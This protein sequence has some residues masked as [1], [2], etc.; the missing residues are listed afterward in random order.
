[1]AVEFRLFADQVER[2]EINIQAMKLATSAAGGDWFSQ[3]LTIEFDEIEIDAEA[4]END[5]RQP[6]YRI[7]DLPGK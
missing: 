3:T 6:S 5:E 2:G 4:G 1:M 7:I